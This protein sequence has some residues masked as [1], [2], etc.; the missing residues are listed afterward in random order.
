MQL[1]AIY[2][3]GQFGGAMF[4]RGILAVGQGQAQVDATGKNSSGAPQG[5]AKDGGE[6][7]ETKD[8]NATQ[9]IARKGKMSEMN[10]MVSQT[11]NSQSALDS[12]NVF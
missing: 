4:P 1:N 8:G 11:N 2:A 7:E 3:E 10:D 6:A 5:N 12:L 9:T